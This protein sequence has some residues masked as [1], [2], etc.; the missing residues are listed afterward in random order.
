MNSNNIIISWSRFPIVQSN[1]PQI[2][3]ACMLKI[4]C[5]LVSMW[6]AGMLCWMTSNKAT[7]M[8]M[9]FSWLK[10]NNINVITPLPKWVHKYKALNTHG[11]K[12]YTRQMISSGL[13]K[14]LLMAMLSYHQ[15]LSIHSLNSMLMLFVI[16]FCI[17]QLK[18][19]LI[20]SIAFNITSF[21]TH[22]SMY[23]SLSMSLCLNWS[24]YFAYACVLWCPFFMLLAQKIF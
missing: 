22:I 19:N 6:S 8:L 23:V 18:T 14:A 16:T 1:V 7:A 24:E 2:T 20:I 9:T 10:N 17:D 12:M 5:C 13:Y 11:H 4:V 15:H 3:C 21:E